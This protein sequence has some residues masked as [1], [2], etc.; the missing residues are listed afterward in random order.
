MECLNV[1][2]NAMTLWQSLK[3][4]TCQNHIDNIYPL[5][6]CCSVTTKNL[7]LATCIYMDNFRGNSVILHTT[8]KVKL[9][10]QL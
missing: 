8:T 5:L 7:V 9:I 3:G 10:L 6:L 2:Q 4:H 1:T